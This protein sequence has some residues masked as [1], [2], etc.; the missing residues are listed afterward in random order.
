MSEHPLLP[1]ISSAIFLQALIQSVWLVLPQKNCGV[2]RRKN[3]TS[4]SSTFLSQRNCDETAASV[5]VEKPEQLTH[6]ELSACSFCSFSVNQG[7]SQ[8]SWS[9]DTELKK[10]FSALDTQ[11]CFPKKKHHLSP[12][13]FKSYFF[14]TSNFQTSVNDSSRFFKLKHSAVFEMKHWHPWVTLF[15]AILFLLHQL[16]VQ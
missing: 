11:P 12:L 10:Y 7:G 2:G 13:G 15:T 1:S 14:V 4:A 16:W 8:I 6:W 3:I 5:Q 9:L